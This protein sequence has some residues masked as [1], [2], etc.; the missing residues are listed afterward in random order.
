[1]KTLSTGKCFMEDKSQFL[2]I[3]TVVTAQKLYQ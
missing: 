3:N 1:M 2:D